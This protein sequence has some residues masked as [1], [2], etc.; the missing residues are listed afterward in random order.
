[1][2]F[3]KVKA[4]L[5]THLK[6]EVNWTGRLD[7]LV[8]VELWWFQKLPF[9][10][11]YPWKV[12]NGMSWREVSLKSLIWHFSGVGSLKLTYLPGEEHGYFLEV[13]MLL[14]LLNNYNDTI[15]EYNKGTYIKHLLG[16]DS[17]HLSGFKRRFQYLCYK[18]RKKKWQF[19]FPLY[20]FY[21]ALMNCFSCQLSLQKRQ[22][23]K[24]SHTECRTWYEPGCMLGHVI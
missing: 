18:R 12:S 10:D 11:P 20:I 16:I 4:T 7:S 2:L 19:K 5:E 23:M 13:N 9:L 15:F 24:F 21:L 3:C 1:M 17:E 6:Y 8:R 22:K 14:Y